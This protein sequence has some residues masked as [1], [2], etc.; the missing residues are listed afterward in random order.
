MRGATDKPATIRNLKARGVTARAT[1]A[2]G[3][4]APSTTTKPAHTAIAFSAM[5]ASASN[6]PSKSVI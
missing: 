6:A 4:H 3:R 1:A 2:V 5:I